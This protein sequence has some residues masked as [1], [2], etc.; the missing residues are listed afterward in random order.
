MNNEPATELG[1]A[2]VFASFVLSIGMVVA[3]WVVGG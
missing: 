2:I 3:A 1:S